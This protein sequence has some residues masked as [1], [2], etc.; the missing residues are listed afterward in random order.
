LTPGNYVINGQ[1]MD[2]TS[3]EAPG[4]DRVQAFLD[5][6]RE[7]GGRLVGEVAP[8]ASAPRSLT[9]SGF[10]LLV[11]IPNTHPTT[12]RTSCSCMRARSRPVRRSC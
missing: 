5:N 4:I 12:T 6:S 3:P 9:A 7:A 2:T 1:A 11:N 10:A 8:G